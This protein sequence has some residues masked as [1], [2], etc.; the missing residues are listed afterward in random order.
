[1]EELGQILDEDEE[2][3]TVSENAVQTADGV[4]KEC[5]EVFREMESILVKKMPTLA[6][7]DGKVGR[8]GERAKRATVMLE[9]LK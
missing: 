2:T 5:L 7:E 3:R 8:G 9:R 4:V 1:M 6:G